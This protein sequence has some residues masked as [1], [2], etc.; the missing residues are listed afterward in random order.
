[1]YIYIYIYIYICIY[2]YIYIYIYIIYIYIIYIYYSG[3]KAT[4]FSKK[5]F[6]MIFYSFVT[7]EYYL[8]ELVFYKVKSNHSV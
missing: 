2:I 7:I 6:D 1:M 5:Y 3:K 4:H 8:Q